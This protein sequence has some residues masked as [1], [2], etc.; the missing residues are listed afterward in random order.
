MNDYY[1]YLKWCPCFMIKL[2]EIVF[3]AVTKNKRHYIVTCYLWMR[4][5]I[6]ESVDIFSMEYLFK[7]IKMLYYQST[8]LD[9]FCGFIAEILCVFTC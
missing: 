1:F 4:Q 3:V 6:F 2:Y 5:R 8:I 7:F 9:C